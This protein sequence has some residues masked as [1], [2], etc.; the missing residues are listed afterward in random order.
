LTRRS[1]LAAPKAPVRLS[2]PVV[3]VCPLRIRLFDFENS[4]VAEAAPAEGL[5]GTVVRR[6]ALQDWGSDWLQL[7]LD[8]PLE[9]HGQPYSQVLVRSRLVN[10]ELGRDKW[11]SVFVLVLP[12]PAVLDKSVVDSKH[13]EHITWSSASTQSVPSGP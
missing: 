10:Y 9:Y 1:G 2:L 7:A 6:L 12:N 13:F 11:A 5:S 4:A 3:R 8:T